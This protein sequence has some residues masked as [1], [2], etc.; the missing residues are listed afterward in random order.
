MIQQTLKSLRPASDPGIS[1]ISGGSSDSV[2]LD[3]PTLL[4]Q[5]IPLTAP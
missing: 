5:F 2:A 3:P 1:G 4:A